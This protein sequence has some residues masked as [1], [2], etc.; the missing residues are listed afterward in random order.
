MEDVI[1][2]LTGKNFKYNSDIDYEKD[3]DAYCKTCNKGLIVN[4]ANF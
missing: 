2:K 4:L 1:K 3:V